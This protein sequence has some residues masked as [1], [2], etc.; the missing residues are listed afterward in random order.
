MQ[1]RK[2]LTL[3][4]YEKEWNTEPASRVAAGPFGAGSL[5]SPE[6]AAACEL[7]I[8]STTERLREF[9]LE[10]QDFPLGSYIYQAF[11]THLK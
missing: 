5:A 7:N 6:L 2:N 9:Y 1:V 11:T 8:S 3:W 10:E 4:N